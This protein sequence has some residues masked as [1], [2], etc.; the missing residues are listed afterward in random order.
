MANRHLLAVNK[1]EE[2]K[3]WLIKNGWKIEKTKGEYEVLRAVKSTRKLPLIVYK[4]LKDNL[5]H[6]SVSDYNEKYVAHFIYDRKNGR[7]K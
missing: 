7:I 3:N 1:L 6:F 4:R 2:F 5:E